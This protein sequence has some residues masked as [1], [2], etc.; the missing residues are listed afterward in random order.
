VPTV[1]PATWRWGRAPVTMLALL[2]SALVALGAL[3]AALSPAGA[4]VQ[5][6]VPAAP[7]AAAL[8]PAIAK[9][10]ATD[11]GRQVEVIVQGRAGDAAAATA[12]V[13]AAGGTVTRD[14]G[15]IGGLVARMSAADAARVAHDPGVRAV[16]LNAA[17]ARSSIDPLLLATS[18]NQS[19]RSDRSWASGFT[20]KGVGVAVIDTGIQGDLPDFRT[21]AIDA[22]SRVVA[23]VVANPEG[24]DKPGDTFGHGTHVAG[25]IAGNGALRP[26]GD[27]LRSRYVGVAPDAH[28]I[29]VKVDDGQ[30]NATVA[31]VIDGLQFVVD[32]KDEHNI[33]V[34]NLSLRSTEKLPARED[35][36]NA[37]VQ[38][39]WFAGLVVVVAAGNEGNAADAVHYAPANDPYVI[40]VGGV[41][42][43]GTKTID[44]DQLAA[45]SSRGT[46]Q[47]GVTKPDVVAPGARLVST[48][49]A[50]SAYT[51]LCP[52]CVVDGQYFRVGGTSM[53]AA[54]VSGMVANLFQ[55]FPSYTPDRMK[56]LVVRRTRAVREASS[57]SGELVD[58]KGK[59]VGSTVTSSSTVT[60]A[61][62]AND[63]AL[64]NPVTESANGGLVPHDLIDRSTLALDWSRTSWSRTS[65]SRT[66][67]SRTSWSRAGYAPSAWTRTS[68]SATPRNCAD[69]ERTS[70]SRTSWSRTSWS[71]DDLEAAEAACVA[72]DPTRTSWS[73]TSWSRTSWSR[74]SWSTAFDK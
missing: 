29:D 10:A 63:K 2:A 4:P 62:V 56:A 16:A 36:L 12:A 26:I 1:L 43:K 61:E 52:Q 73:R 34:V 49:P 18:Y 21:S 13:T 59:P 48:I 24:V 27:T 54:V 39:A 57:T 68:W 71:S 22:S 31:D 70:W 58:A 19:I 11:P 53:A 55:A 66:S 3:Q 50:G 14:L 28:L 46:T 7:S 15:L 9:L 42:D 32:H 45:W 6:P 40:T 17:V 44:D 51:Q 38:Q 60:G 69:F 8:S 33:R 47:E 35:P 30:G 25:L 37:A 72:M 74:T 20:G 64:G 23:N 67:W 65:W 41:D 5:A